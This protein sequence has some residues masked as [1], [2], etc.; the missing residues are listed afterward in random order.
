MMSVRFIC[1]ECRNSYRAGKMHGNLCPSCA[2]EL[3]AAAKRDEAKTE[4]A[5]DMVRV[6]PQTGQNTPA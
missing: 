6:T 5:V 3:F 4:L 1:S 2:R